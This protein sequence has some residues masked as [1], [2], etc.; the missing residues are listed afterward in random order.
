MADT[1]AG[2]AVTPVTAS[3]DGKRAV[4][5]RF[6]SL[7]LARLTTHLGLASLPVLGISAHVFGWI[8][9]HTL[10]VGVLLPL[11]VAVTLLA[12][13]VP[14]PVDRLVATAVGWG[15]LACAA[16]DAF[17]LPTIYVGHWWGDFFGMVGGWAVS[18]HG[19][20]FAV[21]YAW[22]YLGDGG[23]I[24]V[25]FFLAMA[26]LPPTVIDTAGRSAAA[27]I[28]YGICPVWSGLIVTDALAPAG[29]Q[30]FPLTAS[31]V[32][33]SLAGHLIYGGVLGA[34]WWC[35]RSVRTCLPSN[36]RRAHPRGEPLTAADQPTRKA[37]P[38][39]A[40][41]SVAAGAPG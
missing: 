33:L 14:H 10:A 36:E 1:I 26:L 12:T 30:L 39:P 34:G 18:G 25:P 41:P 5:R 21:G 6:H 32:M 31:T 35:S 4:P 23:G 13:L 15:M 11:A 20:N 28:A 29:H 8:H 38:A 7:M 27:G 19:T 3:S 9:L 16:Y 22:R 40:W 24:A 2:Y 17:R 37:E